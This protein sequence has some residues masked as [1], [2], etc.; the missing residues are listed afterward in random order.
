MEINEEFFKAYFRR[1]GDST[2]EIDNDHAWDFVHN[3]TNSDPLEGLKLI[4]ALVNATSSK[5]D[6][7]YV[8]AGPLEDL[9]YCCGPNV[10][11]SIAAEAESNPKLRFALA[12]VWLEEE[13]A[14]Y[15]RLSELE[16]QYRFDEFDP[17]T[18]ERWTEENPHPG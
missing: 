8:A 7:A 18:G 11:E 14:N 16:R 10:D 3:T 1:H 4:L 17:T 5:A 13:D 12:G 6:L 9:P 15:H 2:G